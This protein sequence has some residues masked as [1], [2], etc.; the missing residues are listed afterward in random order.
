MAKED[1]ADKVIGLSIG[2]SVAITA[3]IS[4]I[5]PKIVEAQGDANLSAYAVAL[6]LIILI[7]IFGLVMYAWRSFKK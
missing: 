3:L 6:G 5:A 4:I 1:M 2:L 7:F